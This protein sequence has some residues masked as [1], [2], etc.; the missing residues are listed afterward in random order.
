M[1]CGVLVPWPG[2]E[3]G[4]PQQWRRLTPGRQGTPQELFSSE[5]PLRVCVFSNSLFAV[6][7]YQFLKK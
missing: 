1:A 3:P 4:G 7:P 5:Q 2:I 6:Y